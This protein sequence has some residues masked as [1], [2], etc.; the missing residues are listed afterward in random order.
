MKKAHAEYVNKTL[1]FIA[2][3]E[4]AATGHVTGVKID[5][6]T[7]WIEYSKDSEINIAKIIDGARDLGLTYGGIDYRRDIVKM[8]KSE[9]EIV[10]ENGK[11]IAQ[12]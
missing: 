2:T 4:S 7:F 3:V 5:N 6:S 1:K 10:T 8:G 9:V 11:S 12:I